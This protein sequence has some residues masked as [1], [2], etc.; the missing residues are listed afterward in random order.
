[1]SRRRKMSEEK[2]DTYFMGVDLK[3]VLKRV[4][5]REP[6]KMDFRVAA[7]AAYLM[8]ELPKSHGVTSIINTLHGTV[9]MTKKYDGY[10]L[11][12]GMREYNKNRLRTLVGGM[13]EFLRSRGL[14]KYAHFDAP[15]GANWNDMPPEW[16]MKREVCV[17]EAT[18]LAA[19]IEE[20]GEEYG[21][22]APKP[23]QQIDKTPCP[24]D[25]FKQFIRPHAAE[26]TRM[27]LEEVA[28]DDKAVI[29]ST[30][31]SG[32]LTKAKRK[33]GTVTYS[34]STRF[35]KFVRRSQWDRGDRTDAE[36]TYGEV[37]AL[38]IKVR[39]NQDCEVIESGVE[40]AAKPKSAGF[41][42]LVN[43]PKNRKSRWL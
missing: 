4:F 15:A 18:M 7:K 14:L 21:V 8:V 16:I 1:M 30:W 24:N 32:H 20:L 28:G 5:G 37:K 38:Q 42:W 13:E 3:E 11:V 36:L 40:W 22:D 43:A 2:L 35:G 27:A 12:Q 26:F 29:L 41:E 31:N 9:K 39:V 19:Y 10:G 6:T 25:A 17:F 34:C 23:D 33:D